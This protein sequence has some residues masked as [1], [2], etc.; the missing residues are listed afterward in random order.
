M[1]SKG[2]EVEVTDMGTK[3]LIDSGNEEG[4]KR[5]KTLRIDGMLDDLKYILHALYEK[6]YHEIT[7]MYSEERAVELIQEIL[8]R[9]MIGFE[10][11]EQ[12]KGT[13][14]IRV[15]AE[16]VQSE[17]SSL[18]QRSFRLVLSM[19]KNAAEAVQSK[20]TSHLKGAMY[21]EVN[22]NKYTML[23]KRVL[24]LKKG[25]DESQAYDYMI[26][27]R[28]ERLGRE[29][30]FLC[31]HLINHPDEVEDIDEDIQGMFA[32]LYRLL[33]KSHALYEEYS[34]KGSLAFFEERRQLIQRGI[35][36]TRSCTRPKTRL[37]HYL[38]NIC[39]YIHDLVEAKVLRET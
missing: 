9:E 17:L 8:H 28:L 16:G 2:D 18:L 4:Q 1:L 38:I 13:C 37:I 22:N 6:G 25:M 34:L 5:E 24:Q 32:E 15:I 19:G 11:I 31:N 39:Q 23:C 35:V 29:C 33:E 30:K 7:L 3:V 26:A 36:Y 12:S 27:H 20:E 14:K 10:M 21:M